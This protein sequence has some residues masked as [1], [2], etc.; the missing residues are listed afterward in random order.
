MPKMSALSSSFKIP[1]D[2]NAI[3]AFYTKQ[4]LLAIATTIVLPILGILGLLYL[5]TKSDSTEEEVNEFTEK[6]TAEEEI[7]EFTNTDKFSVEYALV[8]QGV[9]LPAGNRLLD[10]LSFWAIKEATFSIA[11]QSAIRIKDNK[12]MK[13]YALCRLFNHLCKPETKLD[14]LDKLLTHIA[15]H[16]TGND[17][18]RFYMI[19]K[20]FE[21]FTKEDKR[22]LVCEDFLES[23]P[24]SLFKDQ[25][26]TKLFEECVK[27]NDEATA[28]KVIPNIS[29]KEL[30][31]QYIKKY[32]AKW[33]TA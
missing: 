10:R 16:R 13:T 19:D 2:L 7:N 15:T 26:A 11:W 18:V 9:D 17:K 14:N 29:N 21:R 20:L 31:E 28:L 30:K 3:S 23:E 32:L 6:F 5:R 22:E 25:L 12:D 8:L 1:T 4:P 33:G 24:D 27:K